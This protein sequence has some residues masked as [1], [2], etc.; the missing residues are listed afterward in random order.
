MNVPKSHSKPTEPSPWIERFSRAIAAHGTVLDLACGG[1]RHGRLFLARGHAVEFLDR[2]ISAV[3][4]IAKNEL[5]QIIEAD[6]ED[7]SA[8]PLA[9]RQFDLVVVANYLWRPILARIVGAVA[10]GGLLLYET[11]AAG[12]ESFGRPRNPDFLLR[13]GE[14]LE[15]VR[16]R[17]DVLA[18]EQLYQETPSPRIVQHIAARR[19][20]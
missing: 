9:D 17:L 4:D 11:F 7:G 8:W 3:A 15:A 16:G 18:Y 19:P 1:G 13:P 2:D 20:Q 5:A 14:L 12:N 6:L 10:P